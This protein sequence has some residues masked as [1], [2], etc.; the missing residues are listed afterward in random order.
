MHMNSFFIQGN[1]K[2]GFS[3]QIKRVGNKK[4]RSIEI[5]SSKMKNKPV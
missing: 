5:K 3:N 2:N 4:D 1:K